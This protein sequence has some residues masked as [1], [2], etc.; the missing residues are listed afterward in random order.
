MVHMLQDFH[1]QVFVVLVE[2]YDVE[3]DHEVL[4]SIVNAYTRLKKLAKLC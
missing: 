1:E 4:F 2:V 3:Q